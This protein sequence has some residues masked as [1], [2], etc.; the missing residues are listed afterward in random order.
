MSKVS[1][2]K[3]IKEEFRD[4][5]NYCR[6]TSFKPLEPNRME[7]SPEYS[8]HYNITKWLK[9]PNKDLKYFKE[10]PFKI[11][12]SFTKDQFKIIEDSLNMCGN[13]SVGKSRI[14]RWLEPD[15]IWRVPFELKNT[16]STFS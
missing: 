4:I 6:G 2:K 9:N 15:T 7:L 8:F 10:Y 1:H 3:Q 12:F 14:F 11:K 5:S 13:T 16:I